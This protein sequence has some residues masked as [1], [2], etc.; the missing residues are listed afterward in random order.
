[1]SYSRLRSLVPG[2]L[3]R[4]VL[5]FESQIESRL[6]AFAARLPAQTLLLDAG[7]GESQYRHLLPHCRYIG[8]DLAIGDHSWNY[9]KLDALANLLALPFRDR[10]FA[11][12]LSIVTLEHVS[13]PALAL[14]ELARVAQPEAKLFLV[15]PLEWEVHQHPHDYF[16]FTRYA[17]EHLLHSSGWRIDKLDSGG[18]FFRLLSRRLM[19][20]LQ[21][22]PAPLMLLLA[23]PAVPLALLIA[24][25]DPLD[26]QRDYTLGYFVEASRAQ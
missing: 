13:D 7:A 12:F 5:Y 4:Q 14:R 1:M 25:L 18:G 22:F 3:R 10:S 11:A 21:F 24:L 15:V 6:A 8:I 19:N 20:A 23:I 17:V 16:R 26:K 9:S 2:F